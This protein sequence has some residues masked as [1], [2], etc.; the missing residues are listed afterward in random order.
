MLRALGLKS[1]YVILMVMIE[2]IIFSFPAIFVAIIIAYM[3]NVLIS[4]IIFNKTVITSTYFLQ[5][6]GFAYGL[7]IGIVMPAISNIFPVRRAL[8]KSLRDGLNLIR[9]TVN[10]VTVNIAK[11]NNLGISFTQLI[12]ALTLISCGLIAYYFVP[13]S[14]YYGNFELLTLE[15]NI[16]FLAMIIGMIFLSTFV[17]I[18]RAHV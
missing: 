15:L 17:K 2:S 7:V 11:L 9:K 4:I 1:N 10:D 6:I 16:I 18:G 5:P 12:I 14:L 8:S 3:L 13:L